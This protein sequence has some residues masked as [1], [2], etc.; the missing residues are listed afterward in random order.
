MAEIPFP[1]PQPSPTSRRP[2]M[3]GRLGTGLKAS[4]RLQS[5]EKRLARKGA[6]RTV[7]S[8]PLPWQMRPERQFSASEAPES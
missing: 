6:V 2:G 7:D 1:S 3:D 8:P 5:S 4:Q